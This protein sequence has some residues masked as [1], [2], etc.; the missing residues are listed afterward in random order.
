MKILI[1]PASFP[2]VGGGLEEVAFRLAKE[3]RRTGHNVVVITQRYP[4][5][6]RKK[7]ILE[8]VEVYRIL[9]PNLFPSSLKWH[10]LFKYVLG[11]FLAP[12]SLL[13]LFLLVKR[14]KP[15]AVYMHFVGTGAIYLFICRSILSFKL[16][17]TLHGHDVEGLPVASRFHKW[18]FVKTCKVA[19]FVT[20]CSNDLLKKA[21]IICPEIHR[22]STV[23]HNG[24][25]L[26]EFKV[27]AEYRHIR[28]YIF[29]AG[30]FFHKKGFDVL[31]KAFSIML[32]EGHCIDLI[33]AGS[34]SEL[35]EYKKLADHLEI[36]WKE[37]KK[38]SCLRYPGLIF[39]G[40]ATRPEIK[41]L[42]S[43]SEVVV[44]PSRVEPFGLIVLE[45]QAAGTPVIASNVGGISEIINNKQSILVEPED[46]CAIATGVKELL[47]RDDLKTLLV[48]R[49]QERAIEFS[50]DKIADTYISLA[51]QNT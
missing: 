50:W 12:F 2:P 46:E 17:V 27:I 14:E 39:W 6:L 42:I 15:E 10:S 45:A 7:E 1:F 4:R 21:K 47:V 5:K 44:I 18:I 16:F 43:G 11:L 31:I 41:S 22:K 35:E 36:P 38:G 8:N 28:P 13:R 23:I 19:D 32:Q 49:G 9:F 30:R 29:A 34:G 24:I 40:W 25:D 33:L 20:A 26:E 51:N 37:K 3:F 48:K